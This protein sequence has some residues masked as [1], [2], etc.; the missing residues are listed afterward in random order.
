MSELEAFDPLIPCMTD[1]SSSHLFSQ[2]CNIADVFRG[3]PDAN[4]TCTAAT[5]S[6]SRYV[7][8]P[9]GSES[10]VKLDV[11]VQ[12]A[13]ACCT[14]RFNPARPSEITF[15]V[16]GPYSVTSCGAGGWLL[17]PAQGD[18]SSYWLPQALMLRLRAWA[19]SGGA[20]CRRR[21]RHCFF[22]HGTSDQGT[23]P[24]WMGTSSLSDLGCK[25]I[26]TY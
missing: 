14:R 4:Y 15:V 20:C 1:I 26:V 19:H 17:L 13:A 12:N 5:T 23:D 16:H 24:R 3:P 2:V 22:A 9:R 25:M 10:E 6:A 18:L 7:T 21:Q 8:R 11:F